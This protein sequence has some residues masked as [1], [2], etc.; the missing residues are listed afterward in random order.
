MHDQAGFTLILHSTRAALLPSVL[1]LQSTARM[2]RP[3]G[4][5]VA[6]FLLY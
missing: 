1:G 2:M 4:L 3:L 5:R 6:D